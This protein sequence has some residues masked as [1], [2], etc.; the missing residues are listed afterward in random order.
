MRP[1][2]LAWIALALWVGAAVLLIPLAGKAGS[3]ESTD[4]S[5]EL[6][7]QAEATRAMLQERQSFP[8]ADTPVAVVVYTR[9]SG[10]TGPDRSTVDADRAA[11]AALSPTGTV[12]PANTDEKTGG[13]VFT[14]ESQLVVDHPITIGRNP[15]ER[16][17]RAGLT[18]R[19]RSKASSR[20]PGTVVGQAPRAGVKVK[21][22]SIVTLV[23]SHLA[24]VRVPD[25]VGRS[26]DDAIA[27]LTA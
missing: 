9:D 13:L 19:L 2:H 15:S 17:N 16:I 23:V 11:F 6:P 1:R 7:R 10:I 21:K 3:V 25:V 18:P 26:R 22:G 14:R 8:G 4:P 20:P 27:A 5:L 24:L 12:D